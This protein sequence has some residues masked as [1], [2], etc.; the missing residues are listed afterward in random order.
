ADMIKAFNSALTLSIEAKILNQYTVARLIAKAYNTA[1]YVGIEAKL[2]D[3][4]IVEK[5]IAEAYMKAAALNNL[6][7]E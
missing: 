6:K 2:Y 7:T 5:L 3:S 4:G 1:M